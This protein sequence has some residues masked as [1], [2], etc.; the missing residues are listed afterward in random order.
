MK[1]LALFYLNSWKDYKSYFRI[2]IA[3]HVLSFSIA[4]YSF[5]IWLLD[6]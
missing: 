4:L 1:D 3:C 6:F 5:T 2:S